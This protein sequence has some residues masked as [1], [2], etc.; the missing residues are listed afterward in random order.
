MG[1][2]REWPADLKRVDAPMGK[3]P[4]ISDKPV[5]L[6]DIGGFS[7]GDQVTYGGFIRIEG[8]PTGSVVARMN[9]DESFRG[10]DIFLQDGR[11]ASHVVDTWEDSANKIVAKQPLKSGQWHHVMITFDGST[12]GHQASAIY[13]D[14][15]RSAANIDP[16]TV[17]GNI[18]TSVPLRLGA[19]HKDASKLNRQR[20]APGF[21]VLPTSVSSRGD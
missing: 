7:R 19:R 15:K 21:P 13:V 1:W 12:S 14:G 4:V 6:G 3:A 17:G 2:P 18:E 10:W 20:G 9:P 16:N 5:D 11:P 8:K